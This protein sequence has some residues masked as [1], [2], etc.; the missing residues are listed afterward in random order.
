MK[1]Y[2]KGKSR[3]IKLIAMAIKGFTGTIGASAIL[4]EHPYWGLVIL[5]I[6]AAANEVTNFINVSEKDDDSNTP[7]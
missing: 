3:K 2:A 5:A 4:M 6:G 7:A 1:Y